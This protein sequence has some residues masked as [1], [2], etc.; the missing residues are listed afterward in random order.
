MHTPVQLD[1][2]AAKNNPDRFRVGTLRYTKAGLA[3]LFVWIL[4]G[5]F[6]FI[7]METVVPSV[8]PIKLNALGAPNW[9]LGFI[10]GAIPNLMNMVFNP[11][12][13]FCSDRYRSRWGRRIPFLFVATP[14][15]VL[16]L[17]A[18]GCSE[19]IGGWLHR[20][21]F[22]AHASAATQAQVIIGTI[23]VLMVVFQL[24]N[25]V[26]NSVYYYLFNDVV[27]HAFLARFMALF[28]MV[29]CGAAAVFNYFFFQY[30]N[31]HMRE[32][33]IGAALLY[34][35]A[36]L[37]MCFKVKE[38]EYPPAAPLLGNKT[39]L[40]SGIRTYFTECFSTRL[41][42]YFFLANSLWALMW[43]GVTY[44]VF[45]ARSVGIS[46]AEFGKISGGAQIL[47][48]LLL[49]PC[50]ILSDRYHPLRTLI[51]A[52]IALLL[53]MPWW[54]LF[55][56]VNMNPTAVLWVYIIITALIMPMQTLYTAAEL[57]MYMKILPPE[58]YGQLC[59]ANAMLRSLIQGAGAIVLGGLLDWITRLHSSELSYKLAPAWSLICMA[60]SLVFLLL[61]QRDWNRRGGLTGYQP[62]AR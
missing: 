5:D 38:G 16:S 29:S 49:Y 13:S 11:I 8:V 14:L 19:D 33:F 26:I 43:L 55:V 17:V 22:F 15:V 44:Q 41:Y 59:S 18:L 37:T 51:A 53:L 27:P 47:G 7:L 62:P 3:L 28:R 9:V 39:G 56:F 31:T 23:A 60:G 20:H 21:F 45:M 54:L 1:P 36:F 58:R 52:Q 10:G 34:L 40:I 12:S 24:F 6:C 46:L 42:W 50:G 48:T 2:E 35:V 4:W 30:A 32:I 57:P 61:L 25:T